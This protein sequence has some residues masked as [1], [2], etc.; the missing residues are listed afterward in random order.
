MNQQVFGERINVYNNDSTVDWVHIINQAM[1]VE[2]VDSASFNQVQAKEMFAYFVNG[3]IEHS[4]AKGNVYVAYFLDEDDGNRIG[5][6]YTETS[7]LKMYMENKKMKKI[8]MPAGSGTLFSPLNIPNDKKYLP[9]FAWFD[10]IRPKNKDDVFEWRDKDAKN[11]LQT[12]REKKVPLQT[13][14]QVK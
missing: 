6:N 2:Q 13:L 10:Y 8:W 5:M 7:E 11:I 14:D 9:A 1:T 4:E 12:T 3:Q